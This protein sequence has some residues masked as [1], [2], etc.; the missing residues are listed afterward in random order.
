MNKFTKW[1]KLSTTLFLVLLLAFTTI[2]PE[3]I[4]AVEEQPASLV[5]NTEVQEIAPSNE[6]ATDFIRIHIAK[7]G[8]GTSN[9]QMWLWCGSGRG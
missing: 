3:P 5:P 4:L 2:Q 8:L 6:E 7:A 9:V 1:F